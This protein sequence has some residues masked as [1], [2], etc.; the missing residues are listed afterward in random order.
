MVYNENPSKMDDLGVS[1]FSETRIIWVLCLKSMAKTSQKKPTMSVYFEDRSAAHHSPDPT[2]FGNIS[3]ILLCWEIP[4]L[5]C[6]S[7]LRSCGALGVLWLFGKIL[8]SKM[9]SFVLWGQA[10]TLQ[11][12]IS[13]PKGKLLLVT[14]GKIKFE[15]KLQILLQWCQHRTFL[16][17]WLP[18][19]A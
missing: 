4:N 6:W 10:V 18:A 17:G 3:A 9:A 7:W 14:P 8:N 5:E 12:P 16:H 19:H 2:S 13:A 11:N 15:R 1:L